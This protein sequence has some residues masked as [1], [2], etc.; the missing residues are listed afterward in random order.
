M[1]TDICWV[2]AQD[3]GIEFGGLTWWDAQSGGL[4][5]WDEPLPHQIMQRKSK[6]RTGLFYAD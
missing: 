1:K 2:F 5:W 4:T 6:R 3:G